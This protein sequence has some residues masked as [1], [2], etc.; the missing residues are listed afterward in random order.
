[1]RGGNEAWPPQRVVIGDDG[2]EEAREAGDLEARVG[3][4]FD[5]KVLLVRAYPQLPELDIE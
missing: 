5:A 1:M 4:S 3:K 2:S